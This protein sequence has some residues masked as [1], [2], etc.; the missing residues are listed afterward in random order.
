MN[1]HRQPTANTHTDT[2]NGNTT[3]CRHHSTRYFLHFH[4]KHS[5]DSISNRICLIIFIKRDVSRKFYAWETAV[6][7]SKSPA[8]TDNTIYQKTTNRSTYLRHNT[9]SVRAPM[10]RVCTSISRWMNFH[11]ENKSAAFWWRWCRKWTYHD[12]DRVRGREGR[13]HKNC[14]Y[15]SV[16]QQEALI[17]ENYSHH[18]IQCISTKLHISRSLLACNEYWV[19]HAVLL[20]QREREKRQNE[21]RTLDNSRRKNLWLALQRKCA[22]HLFLTFSDSIVLIVLI[23]CVT[24]RHQFGMRMSD[25]VCPQFE[26]NN[27]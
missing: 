21:V 7:T 15:A 6:A 13:C 16:E 3:S 25:C 5:A 19:R 4:C 22:I 1:E 26:K 9:R 11:F 24:A 23:C 14:I 10:L 27:K 17:T 12:A 8:T 2:Q 18:A 20:A